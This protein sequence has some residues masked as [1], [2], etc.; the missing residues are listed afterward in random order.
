MEDRELRNLLG[1]ELEGQLESLSRV[2]IGSKEYTAA[3]EGFTKLYRL[4]I[5]EAKNELDYFEKQDRR[6]MERELHEAEEKLKRDQMAH[7]AELQERE[8][9]LKKEA[10]KKEWIRWAVS[11]GAQVSM[12]VLGVVSYGKLFNKG[13]KFEET[14][15]VVSTTM[16]GLLSKMPNPW[17]K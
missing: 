15:T 10:D 9:E 2:E 1:E 16:R 5:D 4:R 8:A 11:L 12:T 7:E 6:T 17:R 13:L 3:V 14:G